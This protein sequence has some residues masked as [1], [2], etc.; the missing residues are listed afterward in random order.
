MTSARRKT[1]SHNL[2]TQSF[3]CVVLDLNL[4]DA[5][6]YDVLETM[7]RSE[8]YSFPPV[9]VYTGGTLTLEDEERLR[10][11][12]R[13]VIVKGARSPERLLDEVTLFLHQVE[14]RL[15]P[16]SRGMLQAARERDE[17]FEGR[18]ILVVE[19][20]VRNVFA[21]TSVFEPRGAKVVIARNGREDSS[22]SA[23]VRP[24]LVLMDIMMPEMDGLTAIRE[25]RKRPEP[26]NLPIIA[27]TAKAMRDDHEE[28]IAAGASDYMP[29]P[30]DV[31]KLCLCRRYGWPDDDIAPRQPIDRMSTS[32]SIC[33]WRRSTGSTPTTSATMPRASL[34]RRVLDALAQFGVES[35]SLLQHGI[36]RDP[37]LVH[38]L[39]TQ[40]TVPVSDLFRDPG[41]FV[42]LRERG[43]AA[44]RHLP[45]HQGLG[46]RL[47]HGRRGVLAGHPAR[48]SAAARPHADLC[49]RH[50]S[51]S[52][53]HG[54][55]GRVR[56]GSRA[57][58]HSQLPAGR[59][60]GRWPTTTRPRTAA[61]SST[62]VCARASRSRTIAWPR[63]PS[64]PKCTW[65]RA[66]TFSSTST[67][68]CRSARSI[69][70]TIAGAAG[71]PW[72]RIARTPRLPRH[73]GRSRMSRATERVYRRSA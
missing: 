34:R 60:C 42:A 63:I 41:Y 6:G 58:V 27:L 15:P 16:D 30:L 25:L 18:T 2:A 22:W 8:Q 66:A 38:R 65:C 17:R 46:R 50:Q 69:S 44:A 21:L 33:C 1:R 68:C 39:L 7:A 59:W 71:L 55:G 13:S 47:Q 20:D 35:V 32:R 49:H 72:A 45:V 28:C 51:G 54:R 48:G 37:A 43:S 10:R 19:D 11:F 73:R 62:A 5:S 64:S 24:D 61:A 14:S 26:R 36:L 53:A 29:K 23:Q 52:A 56:H 70:S 67:R 12:S 9:I 57:G 4:P 3:D 31:D 40:L